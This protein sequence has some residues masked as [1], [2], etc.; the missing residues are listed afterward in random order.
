MVHTAHPASCAYQAHPTSPRFEIHAD[1]SPQTLARIVGIFAAQNLV[2]SDLHARQS[3]AGIWIGLHIDM[4]AD[5]AEQMAEKLRALV[6]TDAV[7]LV[8]APP[9]L[10][11]PQPAA[12]ASP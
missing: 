1:C 12:D 10:T 6:C 7:I 8:P 9:T 11:S 5:H 4:A 2:P 3:C